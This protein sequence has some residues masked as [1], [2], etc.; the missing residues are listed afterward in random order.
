MVRDW[1]VLSFVVNRAKVLYKMVSEPLFCFTDVEE[2]TSGT[3]DTI[4]HIDGCAGT[5]QTFHIRQR[6]TFTF[7]NVIYC[8]HCSRCGL[9]YI[10]GTT[11]RL[12]DCFVEH[13]CLVRDKEQ[14]L[15]VTNHFNS[16]SHSLDNMSILGC[17]QCHNDTMHKL[18]EQHL[19][20]HLWNLQ[21]NGLN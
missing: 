6:F 13:L 9:L 3:A 20:F 5:K 18:E 15:P 14:H 1:E 12:R 17:L 19:I 2:A 8:I 10:G 21:P 7:A 4:G 11:W 16:P